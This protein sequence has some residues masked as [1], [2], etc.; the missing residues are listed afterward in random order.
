MFKF[1]LVV[2]AAFYAAAFASPVDLSKRA[3]A[4]VTVIFARGTIE[5]PTIGTFVGPS[6]QSNTASAISPKTLDFQGVPYAADI[7]GFFAGGDAQ[8]SQNMADMA[9]TAVANCPSTKVVLS[10][11]SQGA[12]L[13]HKASALISAATASHVAAVVVFGDPDKG[14]AFGN[15]LTSK[16]ITFCRDGD[17][18]CDG[19]FL[20]LPVHFEYGSDTPAAA[21]F[22]AGKV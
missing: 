2:L 7:A 18:I 12:Q 10:G 8:G 22:I 5:T 17:N 19:G 1:N 3:C 4:D 6:L 20:T 16:S 9:A 13:V 14:Q 21:K 11:Y 15:S